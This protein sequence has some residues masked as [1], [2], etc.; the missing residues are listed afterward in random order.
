MQDLWLNYYLI[1][2]ILNY[3][4]D[5]VYVSI[6]FK[7]PIYKIIF[8]EFKMFE[9]VGCFESCVSAW[10]AII[11]YNPETV[12]N[13]VACITTCALNQ[14]HFNIDLEEDDWNKRNTTRENPMIDLFLHPTLSS[15]SVPITE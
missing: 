7:R 15:I 8:V 14:S 1:G 11:N 4:F 13:T 6:H 9:T 12:N 5:G 2:L 3:P 10:L